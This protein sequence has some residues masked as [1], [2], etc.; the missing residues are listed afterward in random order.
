MPTTLVPGQNCGL[1]ATRVEARGSAGASVDFCAFL[2]TA[3]GKARGDADFIFYGQPRNSCVELTETAN[4]AQFDMDLDSVPAD[5]ERIAICVSADQPINESFAPLTLT[6]GTGDEELVCNVDTES[7]V[8]KVLILGQFYRRN[9][10]W[11]FRFVEQG[12]KGGLRA[13]VEY[14]GL[15]VEDEDA[16]PPHPAP[17][18]P[19]TALKIFFSYGHDDNAVLVEKIKADLEKRNPDWDIW[20][21]KNNI[22]AGEDWRSSIYKGISESD[23][24]VAWLSSHSVRVPGVCL[25]ELRIAA[26]EP[27][28]FLASVLLESSETVAPPLS[29]SHIQY[30]DLSQ[31]KLKRDN[32]QARF[33]SWLAGHVASL[34]KILAG[35]SSFSGDIEKLKEALKI[36]KYGRSQQDRLLGLLRDGFVGREWLFEEIEKWLAEPDGRNVFCVTGEPGVG[37]SALV[38]QLASQNKIQVAGVYFCEAGSALDDPKTV[39]VS[40][41]YQLGT[42]L[43]SYRNYLLAN[44]FDPDQMQTAEAFRKFIT[45]PAV[46]G[47]DGGQQRYLLII[48]ALDEAAEELSM[49]IADRQKELPPWLYLL[50]TSR[51]NEAHIKPHLAA[52][53]PRVLSATDSRNEEDTRK[54]AER[55]VAES[56]LEAGDRKK[57]VES[58]NASAQGNF[59]Y[60]AFIRDMIKAGSLDPRDFLQADIFPSGLGSLYQRYMRQAFPDR[61]SFEKAARVILSILAGLGSSAINLKL[62]GSILKAQYGL[63]ES[64]IRDALVRLGSLIKF[65]GAGE[66]RTVSLYHKSVGDWLLGDMNAAY[67]LDVEE[68]QN[69][70]VKQLWS[71]FMLDAEKDKEDEG[72]RVANFTD[73]IAPAFLKILFN[74]LFPGDG[75]HPRRLDNPDPDFLKDAGITKKS[76]EKYA[77]DFP[78][79]VNDDE[80]TRYADAI[81][82]YLNRHFFGKTSPEAA[83]SA[84][85]AKSA[86]PT[87]S[88]PDWNVSFYKSYLEEIEDSPGKTSREYLSALEDL[89][90]V[91]RDHPDVRMRERRRPLLN[92]HLEAAKDTYKKNKTNLA[93]FYRILANLYAEDNLYDEAAELFAKGLKRARKD[94]KDF[95]ADLPKA[96]FN[97]AVKIFE[98]GVDIDELTNRQRE[99]GEK[100]AESDAVSTLAGVYRDYIKA[101]RY[102]DPDKAWKLFED[103]RVYL[104]W[105]GISDHDFDPEFSAYGLDDIEDDL[106]L[107]TNNYETIIEYYEKELEENGS[108]L[109]PEDKVGIY[110]KLASAY[111]AASN[112]EEESGYGEKLIAMRR[113]ILAECETH[114][115]DIEALNEALT[116]LA[117]ALIDNG[118]EDEGKAIARRAL[119]L[120]L[121]DAEKFASFYSLTL[122]LLEGFSEDD[123]DSR[124]A[125]AASI[126]A[127][128]D[129]RERALGIEDPVLYQ[130]YR[131]FLLVNK[132]LKYDLVQVAEKAIALAERHFGKD[133]E[134]Y[135]SASLTLAFQL[136]INERDAERALELAQAGVRS[137]KVFRVWRGS[138][139]IE[140]DILVAALLYRLG[141]FDECIK[142]YEAIEKE[143]YADYEGDDENAPSVWMVFPA[144]KSAGLAY[145]RTGNKKKAKETLEK[146]LELA[147]N[148]DYGI[149]EE[150]EKAWKTLKLK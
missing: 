114:P 149:D 136:W 37:K 20:F 112:M 1:N 128:L 82:F 53:N 121:T 48:D 29:I 110:K 17:K 59:R 42:R 32:D 69:R 78:D 39:L 113:A 95:I 141:R 80:A 44:K 72:D 40:L 140:N 67:T 73:N 52:L 104:A 139:E 70:V 54:F 133:S 135:A 45:E 89:A 25:D 64:D 131:N 51:P 55:I 102:R 94:F 107:R 24:V 91:Y 106:L 68:A 22:R 108:E 6:I 10:Q 124:Q 50:V 49:F 146:A 63:S 101:T 46:F 4:A 15:E 13:L 126:S 84:W 11:K 2:L 21:D 96:K 38:A 92:G 138:L 77:D 19:V 18:P 87:D 117:E 109:E 8:E 115:A 81:I 58:M 105:A 119:E 31:W 148:Y 43:P 57:V 41:A 33:D 85:R 125:A 7:R 99:T 137:L 129:E 23:I 90:A 120:E 143:I 98:D 12:F 147:E 145:L 122:G 26:S 30:L 116:N 5:V 130:I 86:F 142:S 76:F 132:I 97:A 65:G 103:G 60:L 79:P 127:F 74:R 118:Q 134:E 47:I 36:A 88:F 100:L 61:E 16:A 56:G 27:R 111:A 66:D 28:H 34:E 3:D 35:H 9:G 83:G 93:Q 144:W 75:M 71:R 123:Q 150:L 62:L 14:Y